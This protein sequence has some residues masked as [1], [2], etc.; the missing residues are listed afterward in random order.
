[1]ALRY[2]LG[3]SMRQCVALPG[4]IGW[5]INPCDGA[6]RFYMAAR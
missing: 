1:M 5:H 2:A 3:L 6:S 4:I